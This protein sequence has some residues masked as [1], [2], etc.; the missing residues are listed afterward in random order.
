VTRRRGS[1]YVAIAANVGIAITKFVAAA[2]SGSS[3]M[4]SEGLHSVVDTGDGLLLLLGLHLARRGPTE[5]HPYGHGAEVYFWS[6][7]VAM[8]IFGMG[9]CVSIYEGVLHLLHPAEPPTAVLGLVVLGIA[10]AFEGTSWLVALRGFRRTGATRGLWEDIERSKDPSTFVVLLEDSAALLGIVFA[11]IGLS[12]AHWL[13]APVFDALA[14]IA[15]GGLLVV[16]GMVLGRETRSLLLGESATSEIV[17]SIRGVAEAQPGVAHAC[18]PRT[19]HLGPDSV[20]VDLDLVLEPDAPASE[21]S[22]RVEAAVRD[23]HPQVRRVSFR[24][25]EPE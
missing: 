2:L 10:F 24:F 17:D 9:G 12:L 15:I 13:H 20:H 4:F 7:V 23:R 11:A 8:S 16:I 1:V 21:L 14:S 3:A 5:R 25:V 18:A 6:T 22:R 19:M